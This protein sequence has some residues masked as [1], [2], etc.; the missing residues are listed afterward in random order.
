MEESVVTDVSNYLVDVTQIVTDTDSVDSKPHYVEPTKFVDVWNHPDPTQQ[1]KWQTAILK[2]CG[3]MDSQKV[4]TRL[5][6]SNMPKK[7]DVVL[8]ADGYSKSSVMAHFLQE[9]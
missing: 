6:R 7:H 9:L 4:Y 5:K 2:E 8:R 3:G 1:Q